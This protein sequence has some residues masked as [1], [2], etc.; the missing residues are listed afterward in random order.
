MKKSGLEFKVG[1]FVLVALAVLTTLVFKAGDFYIKPGYT[2][3]FVF[4]FVSGIDNGSSVKLAGVN[5]GEVKQV[6]VVRSPEGESQ[7]EVL[8]WIA[9]GVYIEANA[10]ALIKSGGFLGDK[11]IEILPGVPGSDRVGNNGTLIGKN[12]LVIEDIAEGTGQLVGKLQ[13]MTDHV[14]SVVG[15]PE[16]KASLKNTFNNSDRLTKNMLETSEDLKE[17]AKSAKIVMARLRDGEGS[18]GRLMKDDQIAKDLEA[19]AADLKANPWKLLK[20]S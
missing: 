20:R 2:V 5:V 3:R 10:K 1:I 17:A 4:S 8:A 19:L 12:P 14:N 13:V 9:Q 7:V 11:Y 18:V 15:D 16:F 6:Q